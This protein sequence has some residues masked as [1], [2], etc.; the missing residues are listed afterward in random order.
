MRERVCRVTH[1]KAERP[2]A[3]PFADDGWLQLAKREE[4]QQEQQQ[5]PRRLV[6][7]CVHKVSCDPDTAGVMSGHTNLVTAAPRATHT[8]PQKDWIEV[9]GEHAFRRKVG[10]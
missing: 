2:F 8:W 6:A 4:Q 1:E 3:A 5:W 9:G 10:C 7:S